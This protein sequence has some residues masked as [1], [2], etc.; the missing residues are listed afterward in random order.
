MRK[1]YRNRPI[2]TYSIEPPEH[3]FV[4]IDT[5]LGSFPFAN[6]KEEADLALLIYGNVICAETLLSPPKA[7]PWP[8]TFAA[9]PPATG[10]TGEGPT[11]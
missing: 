5:P 8:V 1:R 3:T 4:F 11:G 10:R 2:G 7:P 9:D 6:T